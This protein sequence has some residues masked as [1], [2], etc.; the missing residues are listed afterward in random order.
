MSATDKVWLGL[1][2]PSGAGNA[3][4]THDCLQVANVLD[5]ALAVAYNRDQL[6]LMHLLGHRGKQRLC[7]W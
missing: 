3:G 5:D 6:R 1:K 4:V 2:V 7:S